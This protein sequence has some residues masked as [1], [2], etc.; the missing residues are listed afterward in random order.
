MTHQKVVTEPEINRYTEKM[1]NAIIADY[2]DKGYTNVA[3]PKVVYSLGKK[4]AK[5]ILEDSGSSVVCF[6]QLATGDIFKAASWNTPTK[7]VVGNIF[8]PKVPLLCGD[9]YAT[10]A[11]KLFTAEAQGVG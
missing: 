7:N 9:F 8:L 3:P 10:R 5:I 2:A 1:S 11:K 4:N 6:V